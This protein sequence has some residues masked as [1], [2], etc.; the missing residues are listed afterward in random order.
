VRPARV[1][2]ARRVREDTVKF[3]IGRG[4]DGG[5][6]G[7]QPGRRT[8]CWAGCRRVAERA[9]GERRRWP[10]PFGTLAG[11][12]R[13]GSRKGSGRRGDGSA[14][15]PGRRSGRGRGAG[16]GA[17]VPGRGRGRSPGP[18][19]PAGPSASPDPGGNLPGRWRDPSGKLAGRWPEPG[20]TIWGRFEGGLAG[21]RRPAAPATPARARSLARGEPADGGRWP[22]PFGTLA[23]TFGDGSRTIRGGAGAV[24]SSH[25]VARAP[26]AV[27]ARSGS[28]GRSLI[29]DRAWSGGV[30]AGAGATPAWASSR[31]RPGR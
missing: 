26:R 30:G 17:G 3:R 18:R 23:G 8:A 10:D 4:G 6:P 25:P 24:G 14:V 5:S 7:Q 12:F 16:R 22:D 11:T 27:A 28:P 1:G 9:T 31:C 19:R 21:K 29:S 13:D 15:R 20:G 2:H